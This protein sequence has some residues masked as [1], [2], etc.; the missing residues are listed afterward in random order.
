MAD[1]S[2]RLRSAGKPLVAWVIGRRDDT[3]AF[4]KEA[5]VHGIPVFTELSRAAECLAAILDQRRKPEP[6]TVE[7]EVER[8]MPADLQ[9]LLD[10][11]SGPLD[12]QLSKS[13][14]GACGVPTV[15]EVFAA[16]AS[17]AVAAAAGLGYPV[18]MK[19]LLPGEVHKT[20]LGL[21]RLGLR[22]GRAV[23]AAFT[24]LM[25]KMDGSGKVLVQ[26]Q[27]PKAVELILGLLRDPQFGPCVMIG[28]GGVMAE[29][30]DDTAFAVAP[31]TH[32][33]ALALIG[34]IRAQKLLSG[35]RGAPPVDREAVARILVSLGAIGINHPRIKEIDINPLIVG[36]RGAT[37]VDA[38]VILG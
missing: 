2:A 29:I 7:K 14:L 5:L 13:I 26:K 37:A 22:N 34:R 11:A 30:Y 18:V 10:S 16:D 6:P 8:P 23:R 31:L 4:Q 38:T 20:E 25:G 9:R 19:G 21:I 3:F 35:F 1:L 15:P 32:R 24:D 28:L 27:A 36:G 17:Q 33:E 12:E